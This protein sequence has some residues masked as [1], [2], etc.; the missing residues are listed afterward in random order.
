MRGETRDRKREVL[1]VTTISTARQVQEGK[2]SRGGV[3]RVGPFRKGRVCKLPS[4]AGRERAGLRLTVSGQRPAGLRVAQVGKSSSVAVRPKPNRP[5]TDE[6]SDSSEPSQKSQI[7]SF[8]CSSASALWTDFQRGVN[9]TRSAESPC[10]GPTREAW[11]ESQSQH[12]LETHRRMIV[13]S[14]RRDARARCQTSIR[15]DVPAARRRAH[16]QWGLSC[17]ELIQG[18]HLPM[19]ESRGPLLTAKASLDEAQCPE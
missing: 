13:T 15:P 3:G 1:E 8:S 11:Q 7:D 9:P 19:R 14:V 16:A 18:M 2:D 12:E 6:G 4:K 17:M 5:P 10:G